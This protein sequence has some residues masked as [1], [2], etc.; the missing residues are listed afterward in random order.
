MSKSKSVK[1]T[2]EKDTKSKMKPSKSTKK[3]TLP[4]A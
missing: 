3:V 1:N 4:Q 2:D